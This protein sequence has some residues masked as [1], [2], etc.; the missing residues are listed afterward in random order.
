MI[1][2]STALSGEKWDGKGETERRVDEAEGCA[3]MPNV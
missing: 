2:M 1:I 3:A